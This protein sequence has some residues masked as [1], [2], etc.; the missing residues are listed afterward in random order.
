MDAG[1]ILRQG[2]VCSRSHISRHGG[3]GHAGSF[4][5]ASASNGAVVITALQYMKPC[6]RF[7]TGPASEREP[8][9]ASWAASMSE[10]NGASPL[11]V[12]GGT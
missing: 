1:Q 5:G 12:P 7:R 10:R 9:P 6:S 11:A 8:R 4:S 3:A 2:V